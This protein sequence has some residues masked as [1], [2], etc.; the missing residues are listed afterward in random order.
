MCKK[1]SILVPSVLVKQQ[2]KQHL[3]SVE[4]WKR[5]FSSE[6]AVIEYLFFQTTGVD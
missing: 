3:E 6:N 2:Q 4:L 1:I 5:T